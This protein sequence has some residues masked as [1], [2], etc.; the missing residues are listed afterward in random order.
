MI[1]RDYL[2]ARTRASPKASY[3]RRRNKGLTGKGA[4]RFVAALG[5]ES[6]LVLGCRFSQHDLTG[7][8][9]SLR[10]RNPASDSLD[11]ATGFQ[12]RGRLLGNGFVGFG[13]EFLRPCCH[14]L[15]P[16]ADV[17][18][19]YSTSFTRQWCGLQKFGLYF[20]PSVTAASA[21]WTSQ[22]VAAPWT[23]S[24]RSSDYPWHR[25]ETTR[26]RCRPRA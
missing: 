12:E 15:G 6:T 5:G 18:S 1:P 21:N 2:G 11:L 25:P 9:R 14:I 10:A 17:S 23:C 3:R 7:A 20:F 22:G 8:R 13:G 26:K 24:A 19:D 16:V 4:S